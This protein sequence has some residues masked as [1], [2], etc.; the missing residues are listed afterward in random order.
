VLNTD[1]QGLLYR[2]VRSRQVRNR[3][4]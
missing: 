1:P 2:V 4:L 3:R